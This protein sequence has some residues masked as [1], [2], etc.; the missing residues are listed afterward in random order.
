MWT[1]FQQT[2]SQAGDVYPPNVSPIQFFSTHTVIP[3]FTITPSPELL[4]APAILPTLHDYVGT[5]PHNTQGQFVPPP[6][7]VACH[8]SLTSATLGC[9]GHL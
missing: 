4:T 3:K 8:A 5:I 2:Q 9:L 1:S 6:Y 7:T